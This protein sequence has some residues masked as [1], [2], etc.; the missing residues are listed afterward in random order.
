MKTETHDINL[1][2][3]EE[4]LLAN[5]PYER[6]ETGTNRPISQKRV[7]DYALEMLAG[8]WR[9]THQGIAFNVKGNLVD[10]QHRLMAL[11]QAAR[12]GA[13]DGDTLV[14]ANLKLKVKF[15]VTWGLEE[16]I[17]PYLDNGLPRSAA[18]ILAIAGYSNQ[19]NLGTAA[20]LLYVYDKPNLHYREWNRIKVPNEE[21]LATVRRSGI[22]DYLTY[23]SS[24]SLIG[25]IRSA[26][27]VGSYVCMRANSEADHESFMHQLQ[28][29]ENL[30]RENPILT[31]R[32]YLLRNKGTAGV[33]RDGI[34]HLAFYIKTWN[35]HVAKRRRSAISFQ[36]GKEE[37]PIP[38]GE[39]SQETQSE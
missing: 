30:G 36:F 11:V 26:A 6:G 23:G 13:M 37:F 21:I 33:K 10:G 22:E 16:D 24:L 28:Y 29:G 3:A 2:K 32:N 34:T 27:I 39:K 17:F 19:V 8:R 7:N 12:E 38:V 18:H 15:Q 1:A 31:F 5:L 14:S 25:L 4:W 20:R 9:L 35:D